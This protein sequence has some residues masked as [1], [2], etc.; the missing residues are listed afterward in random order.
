MTRP[1][2]R[3]TVNYNINTTKSSVSKLAQPT[4]P[5][6]DVHQMVKHVHSVRIRIVDRV[7]HLASATVGTFVAAITVGSVFTVEVSQYA[8]LVTLGT[9]IA[10]IILFDERRLS[11]GTFG[12][13]NSITLARGALTAV[14]AG[15]VGSIGDETLAWC[16]TGLALTCILSDGLDGWL[17][18][19]TR[20]TSNFGAR[21]DMEID[22]LTLLVLSILIFDLGKAPIWV[23][24]IGLMRYVFVV[25]GWL[26]PDLRASLPPS[27]RRKFICVVQG[28]SLCV[29]L[30]PII[31]PPVC[32]I[33]LA[34]CLACLTWSFAIDSHWLLRCASSDVQNKGQTAA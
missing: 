23:I 19:K 8:L 24:A 13:A 12:A 10:L 30:A 33:I 3:Y 28:L 5:N 4:R 22:A 15:L 26:L 14:L 2:V 16:A 9:V 11:S 34:G 18:R 32:T 1:H 20:T 6:P 25:T 21:F 31:S 17:A 29:C 27:Q 7:W